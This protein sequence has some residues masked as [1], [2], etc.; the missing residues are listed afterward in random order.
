MLYFGGMEFAPEIAHFV[1]IAGMVFGLV[2]VA[3]LF[4]IGMTQ[5][6]TGLLD[7]WSP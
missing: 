5:I 4:A 2:M 6:L 7:R 3:L 1:S